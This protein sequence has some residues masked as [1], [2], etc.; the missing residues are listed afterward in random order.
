MGLYTSSLAGGVAETQRIMRGAIELGINAM[1]TA[2]A[3][4]DSEKTVGQ[5]IAALDAPL[6]ITTQLGGRPQPFDPQDINGLRH[7]GAEPLYFL[8]AIDTIVEPT[9]E[10]SRPVRCGTPNYRSS[11]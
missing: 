4:A 3:H 5:A 1:D 2:P 9:P 6:I 8:C 11:C 10:Q 7:S